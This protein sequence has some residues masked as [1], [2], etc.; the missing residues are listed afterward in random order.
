MHNPSLAS[1]IASPLRCFDTRSKS[2]S[3]PGDTAAETSRALGARLLELLL[4]GHAVG[5]HLLEATLQFRLARLERRFCRLQL[6][7][8]ELR[9]FHPLEQPV[10]LAP[11]QRLGGGDLGLHRVVF[12]VGLDLHQLVFVLAE[13]RLHRGQILFGV[14]PGGLRGGDA[15][16]DASD[17]CRQIR[18]PR[19]ERGLCGRKVRHPPA[20][21]LGGRIE[22]LESDEKFE[23][24]KHRE[25]L[26]AEC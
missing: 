16:F 15:F 14:A 25:M 13:A 18:Q 3:T 6:R 10:L 9:F 19:L 22:L 20:Q 1:D 23:V 17:R 12:L 5:L 7:R 11:H 24:R 2:A 4:G 21:S 8:K 26:N